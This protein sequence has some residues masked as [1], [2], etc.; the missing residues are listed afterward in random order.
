MSEERDYVDEPTEEVY[1]VA[2]PAP[3]RSSWLP[4]VSTSISWLVI[5][6]LVVLIVFGQSRRERGPAQT[7]AESRLD[8]TLLEMQARYLVGAGEMF[9]GQG[10]NFFGQASALDRGTV[11]QR[12]R[13]ITVA[14]EMASPAEAC[15]RIKELRTQIVKYKVQPTKEQ[16]RI[17]AILDRLYGDFEQARFDAPSLMASERQLL[18][19]KLGWFGELA[20]HPNPLAL[21]EEKLTAVGGTTAAAAAQRKLQPPVSEQREEV[22]E[23]AT[24]TCITI[25]GAFSGAAMIGF[26]GFAGLVLFIVLIFAGKVHGGIRTGSGRGHIYAET[27]ALWLLSFFGLSFA[28][29]FLLDSLRESFLPGAAV[30]VLSLLVLLWPVLRGVP[31][32]EVRED[33]GWTLGR[34]PLLEPIIG[35]GCYAMALPLLAIGLLITVILIFVQQAMAGGGDGNPFAPSGF[36]AHPVVEA[37]AF[38]DVWERLQVVVLAAVVAPIVEETM[39]RGVLYRHLREVS[40]H[41]GGVLSV[42]VSGTVV[43]FIF[44]VIH[45]QGWV[46]VPVLMSLAYGFAIAREWRGTLI[47]AMVGHGLSN[48]LVT[49]LVMLALG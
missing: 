32:R 7:A 21:T 39:F 28:A 1:P 14:G 26:F 11:G 40:R 25:L 20:L 5:W 23:P 34:K 17:L 4:Y 35:L 38:G 49:M 43:S 12:I 22:L 42:L 8:N 24:R 6:G 37:L 13:F 15:K 33:I 31:W 3:R 10:I 18:E 2:P 9:R 41:F 16:V 44:A 36:P 45:P 19:Q 47:P 30:M 27:F 46:A 48:G 29:H